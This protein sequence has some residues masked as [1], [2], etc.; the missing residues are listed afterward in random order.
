MKLIKLIKISDK[1]LLDMY[2]HHDDLISLEKIYSNEMGF[3]SSR[4]EKDIALEYLCNNKF[5][6]K[7]IEDGDGWDKLKIKYK[8][9][10]LGLR[11]KG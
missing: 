10:D 8:L 9:T 4:D 3:N 6:D 11:L 2:L 5:I 1:L 7:Y